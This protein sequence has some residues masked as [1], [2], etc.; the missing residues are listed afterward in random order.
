MVEIE[1]IFDVDWW[2][3]SQK[4]QARLDAVMA[5][6]REQRESEKELKLGLDNAVNL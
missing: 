3:G 2:I 4:E 6:I 1:I 5:R